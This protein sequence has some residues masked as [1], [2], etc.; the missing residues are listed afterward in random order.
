MIRIFDQ[1]SRKIISNYGSNAEGAFR[2]PERDVIAQ[3]DGRREKAKDKHARAEKNFRQEFGLR[4][5]AHYDYGIAYA[6]VAVIVARTND[7][8][9][10]KT[11]L[12]KKKKNHT[13]TGDRHTRV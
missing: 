7:S 11:K 2:H 8:G 10:E 4:R 9:V 6:V 1:A 5:R 3:T 12:I 13:V